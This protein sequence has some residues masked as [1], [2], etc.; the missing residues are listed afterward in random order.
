[1]AKVADGFG[2]IAAIAE[3]GRAE[4]ASAAV[5]V[6]STIAGKADI[7]VRTVAPLASAH[8]RVA[9]AIAGAVRV[10]EAGVVGASIAIVAV[11]ATA[12]ILARRAICVRVTLNPLGV[13]VGGCIGCSVAAH[14]ITSD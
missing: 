8:L 5:S 14:V 1:M 12:T 10:L 13:A 9:T 11:A 4:A 6:Y 7:V 2:V 3:A